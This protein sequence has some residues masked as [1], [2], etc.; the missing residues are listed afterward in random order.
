MAIFVPWANAIGTWAGTLTGITVAVLIAFWKD[1]FGVQGI[2][3]L[4]IMPAALLSAI[5]IGSLVSL[6]TGGARVPLSRPAH[7]E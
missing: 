1:L 2:S 6:L 7:H 4:W 3:F 5:V